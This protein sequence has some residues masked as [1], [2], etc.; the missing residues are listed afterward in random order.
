[1]RAVGSAGM[2]AAESWTLASQ[3]C[4]TLL[5]G[6]EAWL[7]ALALLKITFSVSDIPVTQARKQYA[8]SADHQ[9]WNLTWIVNGTQWIE[10]FF[11]TPSHLPVWW[12]P[13]NHFML[14]RWCWW[15][16]IQFR[17]LG[18]IHF[19]SFG[20]PNLLRLSPEAEIKEEGYSCIF[21]LFSSRVHFST[22]PLH[23]SFRLTFEDFNLVHSAFQDIQNHFD[24]YCISD[25]RNSA[26]CA[27]SLS[28]G[29]STDNG[30]STKEGFLHFSTFWAESFQ[31]LRR[32]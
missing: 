18:C 25:T 5:Y 4:Y 30:I 17:K 3:S 16:N 27:T 29:T 7:L 26:F 12:S 10:L 2:L 23:N 9:D 8:R 21:S 13:T 6:R 31:Q 1:M 19:P 28:S 22:N 15:S 20:F 24:T 14:S 32:I 11:L